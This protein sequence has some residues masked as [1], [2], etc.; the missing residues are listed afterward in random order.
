MNTGILLH[1]GTG[2][3]KDEWRLQRRNLGTWLVGL[4][5]LAV[6]L[7]EHPVL[8]MSGFSVSEAASL[9]ADR[10]SIVGSLVA[11]LTVPFALDR[12][13]RQHVTPIE[14]SKP[15]EKLAYVVGKFAGA[16]L[17]LAL[18]TI[19]SMGIHLAITLATVQGASVVT[20]GGTYLYQAIMIAFPPLIY[21]A[22][23]TYCL[24]IYIRRPIIIIPLYLSYLI[25]TT[26]T[27]AAADAKFSW[28]SPI[29]RPEYFGHV[30][31]AEWIPT[32]L[33]HQTL[34][35]SLSAGLLALAAYGFQRSRFTGKERTFVRWD[36]FRIPF[37]SRFGVKVRILWGGH[38]VAAL[39]MAIVAIANTMSNPQTEAGLR[40]DYALFGLEFYLPISGLLI[41]TGVMARDKDVGV[42]DLV[43][44]KPVNRWRLLMERLLPA[45]A[46]YG[47][48][49]LFAVGLLNGM[50]QSLT[51]QKALLVSLSTGIYLGLVGMT[52]A[53]VTQSA[54]VGYGA[55]LIYWFFEAAFDGRFTAPFY[56]LIVSN[57]VDRTAGEV[58][59]SPSIWLPVKLGLLLLAVWLFI[60][61]GWLL[62][63]GITRRRALVVLGV[64]IPAVFILGWWLVPI[65]V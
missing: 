59:L 2:I 49:C 10:V 33:L 36:R 11:I 35:L 54:L 43:L 22:S 65:L 20:A 13:R 50:Y 29:V 48:V 44:T 46:I 25:M 9:W 5:F 58:W 30:I 64:S 7:S 12:V 42:L 62:D 15:F 47:I 45:L 56:L 51:I 40:A 53:N 3:S 39:L 34:Y 8:S 63:T 24:S 41:L 23:L 60:L 32:V 1:Q 18:V 19:V 31:P 37:L 38:M 61:N 14:F 55:G 16:V 21:A 57:Q 52:V 6:V 4:F 27:Q 26:A 28:F 17:P